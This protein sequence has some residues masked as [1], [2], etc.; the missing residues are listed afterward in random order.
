FGLTPADAGFRAAGFVVL[1]TVMRPVGGWLSDRIG[2]AHVLSAVLLGIIPFALLLAWTD[3][4]PFT[5]GALGCAVFLGLGN[6]AVF[7]LVPQ[8]FP[9]QTG[10]VTGLVG[11]MGG[12]GGF[13]PPLAPGIF[14]DRLG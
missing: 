3:M 8:L 11:A 4:I 2:G 14:R 12:L 10:A 1:A 6:G 9:Q 13:F 5:L 7:Q